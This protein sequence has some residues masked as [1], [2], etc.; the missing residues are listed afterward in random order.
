MAELNGHG[1]VSRAAVPTAVAAN[2]GDQIFKGGDNFTSTAD[3]AEEVELRQLCAKAWH[4]K[5]AAGEDNPAATKQGCPND[6]RR[7]WSGCGRSIRIEGLERGHGA[8]Q[9]LPN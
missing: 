4:A 3:E 8:T 6:E 7:N 5:E 2:I 9:R 1:F